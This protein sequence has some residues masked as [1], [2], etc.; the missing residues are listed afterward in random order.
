MS[1]VCD[2]PFSSAA[3]SAV[4]DCIG[5]PIHL[6]Y[7]I[8]NYLGE[9]GK[10]YIGAAYACK[11]ASH[12]S[13]SGEVLRYMLTISP[14]YP[15]TWYVRLLHRLT[16]ERIKEDGGKFSL[17]AHRPGSMRSSVLAAW[18][19]FPKLRRMVAI[20][21]Y[22][23]VLDSEVTASMMSAESLEVCKALI[24]DLFAHP[25][26]KDGKGGEGNNIDKIGIPTIE[27]FGLLFVR[28]GVCCHHAAYVMMCEL[29][30]VRMN[31]Y[32]NYFEYL[33]HFA[34]RCQRMMTPSCNQPICLALDR[35]VSCALHYINKL[36]GG[37]L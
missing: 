17:R 1:S 37:P 27:M 19:A 4:A 35:R 2:D 34:A 32:L 12:D 20:W 33:L 7:N 28:L 21:A 24:D 10:E 25:D 36:V 5:V 15:Y 30:S 13:K 31:N 9:S 3:S 23:S 22:C 29:L 11:R 8:I 26:Y 18:D 16:V 14:E 6:A